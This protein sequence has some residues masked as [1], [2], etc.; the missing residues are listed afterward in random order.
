MNSRERVLTL[1]AGKTPDRVPWMA[2]LDYWASAMEQRGDEPQGFLNSEA[3]FDLYRQLGVGFYL[4]SYLPYRAEY[5]TTVR[6]TTESRGMKSRNTLETPIGVLTSERT[7][8]PES[9]VSAPTIRPIKELRD[10]ATLRYVLEHT[11]YEPNY[12]ELLWRLPLIGDLGI[13]LAYLPRSP[14]MEMAVELSDIVTLVDIWVDAPEE[15]DETLQI[16]GRKHDEA[17]AIVLASPAEC[18]MFPEN[19][20]SEMVGKRFFEQYLRPYETRWA[21][22]CRQAS[23]YSFVHMDGTLRGLLHEV[24]SV[25]IDVIEAITPAPVGN[26]AFGELRALAGPGPVLWGGVPGSY[27]TELVDDAEFERM[28]REVLSVM[29]REPRYVLGVGD[30]VPPD[31]LWSRVA[32]VAE[33]VERYGRYSD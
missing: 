22:R 19:L 6:L 32:R 10:L 24:G 16:L 33:L 31:G 4:Q 21:E 11:T 25:G 7:Y 23:K 26:V 9:F 15:L 1:L 18:L 29:V 20:S 30:Q 28:V 5:D 8:L 13:L 14:F 27:F 12:G 3:Y 2:D 17:A